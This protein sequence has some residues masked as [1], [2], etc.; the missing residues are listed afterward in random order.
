MY[1]HTNNIYLVNHKS[2]YFITLNLYVYTR[3]C[4]GDENDVR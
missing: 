4:S 3:N 2:I 1:Y